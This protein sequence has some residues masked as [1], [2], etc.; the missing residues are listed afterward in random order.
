MGHF[1]EGYV[2]SFLR[3]GQDLATVLSQLIP[4][5]GRQLWDLENVTDPLG[6]HTWYEN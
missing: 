2:L 3:P 6:P 1:S 5:L 4:R